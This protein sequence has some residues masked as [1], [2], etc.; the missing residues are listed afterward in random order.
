M[1]VKIE[2][3]SLKELKDFIDKARQANARRVLLTSYGSVEPV[4]QGS[5][6]VLAGMTTVAATVLDAGGSPTIY[7]WEKKGRSK[8]TVTIHAGAGVGPPGGG[9]PMAALRDD[10]RQLLRDEGFEVDEG[11]WT[12]ESAARSLATRQR[13]IG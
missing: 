10:V 5:A 12:P 7:R 8:G 11:E 6:L 9:E 4:K 3:V 1:N 2:R 13:L